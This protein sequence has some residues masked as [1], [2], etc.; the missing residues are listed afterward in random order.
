MASLVT[1]TPAMISSS[2]WKQVTLT[3]RHGRLV[4]CGHL[5]RLSRALREFI[6][7]NADWLTVIQLPTYAPVLNPAEGNLAAAD[8]GQITKAVKR[9]LKQIQYHPEL[10]DGCLAGTL[11]IM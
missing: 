2:G 1:T 4:R 5:R 3:Q 9:R 11:L 10:V 7:A 8:L 6:T